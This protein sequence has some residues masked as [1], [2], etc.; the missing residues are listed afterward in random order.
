MR[1]GVYTGCSTS[2][3]S[4]RRTGGTPGRS[5][6]GSPASPTPSPGRQPA[7]LGC[8]LPGP[9]SLARG[10]SSTDRLRPQRPS[11]HRGPPLCFYPRPHVLLPQLYR[12]VSTSDRTAGR[13]LPGPAVA[14]QQ[15]PRTRPPSRETVG[16]VP[17]PFP[18]VPPEPRTTSGGPAIPSKPCLLQ[19]VRATD[20]SDTRNA[21]ATPRFVSPASK[22]A[23]ASSLILPEPLSRRRSNRR[24]A[25]PH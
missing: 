25:V 5:D 6:P 7:P 20:R 18:T 15:R 8:G 19:S 9:R 22:R 23:T 1:S 12:R 14:P 24:P 13:L 3:R 11:R 17:T 10:A 21:A 16:R 4:T 2:S